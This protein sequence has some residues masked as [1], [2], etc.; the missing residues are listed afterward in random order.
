MFLLERDELLIKDNFTLE[1]YSLVQ[2][3]HAILIQMR[4]FIR[5]HSLKDHDYT[6]PHTI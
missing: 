5:K 2:A 4:I 6:Q 3:I 1:L